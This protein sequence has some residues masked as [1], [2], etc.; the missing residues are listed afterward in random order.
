MLTFPILRRL[1]I[2]LDF[3]WITLMSGKS[4]VQYILHTG[5]ERFFIIGNFKNYDNTNYVVTD[6]NVVNMRNKAYAYYYFDDVS[7]HHWKIA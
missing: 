7:F 2:K 3:F 6:K 4:S 1:L 5:N